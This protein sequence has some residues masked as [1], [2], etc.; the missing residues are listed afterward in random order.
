MIILMASMGKNNEIGKNN[1]NIWDLKFH[2]DKFRQEVNGN[3]VVMGRN[4]FNELSNELE[5][6]KK[7]VLSKTKKFDKAIDK[8]VTVVDNVLD[9]IKKC[10]QLSENK[11]V[12]IVGGESMFNLFMDY[13][14]KM[15]I[16]KVDDTVDEADAFFPEIRLQEWD[17]KILNEDK[18][19]NKRFSFVQ[20]TK[21]D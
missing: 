21:K 4:T 13:A 1:E 12:Y 11:D 7:I 15:Y 6:S 8:S 9:L 17:E 5:N 2:R 19:D 20:Y 14:Q 3:I 10:R 18:E 16:T